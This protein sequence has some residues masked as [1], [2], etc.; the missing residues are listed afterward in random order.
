MTDKLSPAILQYQAWTL[1]HYACDLI[2][3]I[4]EDTYRVK[5]GVSYQ[6]FLIL[7]A[8]AASENPITVV[9]LARSLQRQPNSIST[10]V[11]RMVKQSLVKREPCKTDR[12]LVYVKLSP[13]G[14]NIVTRAAI[15]GNELIQRV[16]SDFSEKELRMMVKLLEKLTSLATREAGLDSNPAEKG[17]EIVQNASRIFHDILA[18]S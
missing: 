1:L 15:E 6:Q 11:D 4:E 18:G 2:T 9:E 5:A 7:L 17:M 8:V 12:R 16:T 3:K 14:K 13:A 10:I